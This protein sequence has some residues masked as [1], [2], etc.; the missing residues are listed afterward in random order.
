MKKGQLYVISGPSG[1]GK[2]SICKEIINKHVGAELSVSM[3]TRKPRSGEVEG[4]NYYFVTENHFSE[5][6]KEKGFLEFAEVYGSRYGTPKAPVLKALDRGEDVILEIEMQGAMQVKKSFRGGIFIFI[7]PPSLKELED[8]LRK[9]GTES[10]ESISLRMSKTIEELSYIDKY[11]YYVIN[12][13]LDEASQNVASI[14]RAE[15]LK[16]NEDT[17]HILDRIIDNK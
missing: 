9:R 1:T 7:L 16:I 8:R 12:D 15:H 14:M 6:L 11:D 13:D 17:K 3:T 2:G 10:E 5:V 4:E